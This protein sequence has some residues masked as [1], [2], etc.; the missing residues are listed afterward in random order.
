MLRRISS[1]STV[2]L[3]LIVLWLGM[4]S[5][6]AQEG[7]Y[8]QISKRVVE[9]IQSL[10]P[11]VRNL[12][13]KAIE[14]E[15][16]T[17]FLRVT[18]TFTGQRG[19]QETPVFVTRDGK[20]VILCSDCIYDLKVDPRRARW[21]REEEQA[22]KV[23]AKIDLKGRPTTGN[24]DAKVVIVEYSDY[25][26]PYCRR[27]HME[28]FNRLMQEYGDKIKFV[29]KQFPLT[30]IHP[31]AMKASIGMMCIHKY[32]PKKYWDA[33]DR[34]F[35]RQQQINPNN[36]RDVFLQIVKELQ[37]DENKVMQCFDKEETRA[38]V[39]ADIQ[40]GMSV[41]VQGTP[42]FF[43]NGRRAN[44]TPYA[45]FKSVVDQALANVESTN[46]ARKNK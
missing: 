10:F 15:K 29:Y 26:C 34:L 39:Q 4:S 25:Q 24:P 43:V 33:H 38:I 17:P 2:G 8:Q 45:A 14:P 3:M 44:W 12:Q 23:M 42:T 21:E 13:V 27:A 41:G 22:R 11:Q 16:G 32:H 30:S 18:L 20:Y 37:L 35:Q 31:W 28:L 1:W 6:H 5:G 40:E 19:Q 46:Q 7:K 9:Y 36:I